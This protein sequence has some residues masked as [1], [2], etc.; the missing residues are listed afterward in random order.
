MRK[1]LLSVASGSLLLIGPPESLGLR[2]SQQ[3]T[4]MHMTERDVMA[5]LPTLVEAIQS[6]YTQTPDM[7]TVDSEESLPEKETVATEAKKALNDLYDLILSCGDVVAQNLKL[8][9]TRGKKNQEELEKEAELAK[10]PSLAGDGP[11]AQ[12]PLEAQAAEEEPVEKTL[13]GR[14][15]DRVKVVADPLNAFRFLWAPYST[16][17]KVVGTAVEGVGDVAS[18]SAKSAAGWFVEGAAMALGASAAVGF[19][20]STYIT[21]TM[22]GL[23]LQPLLSVLNVFDEELTGIL[24]QSNRD[25]VRKQIGLYIEDRFGELVQPLK[26]HQLSFIT[27]ILQTPLSS[28]PFCMHAGKLGRLRVT[29]TDLF[30]VQTGACRKVVVVRGDNGLGVSEFTWILASKVLPKIVR[31]MREMVEGNSQT[32]GKSLMTP[33]PMAEKGSRR[34]RQQMP[35]LRKL[36]RKLQAVVKEAVEDGYKQYY[37]IYTTDPA[38]VSRTSQHVSALKAAVT[39][40]MSDPS[41]CFRKAQEPITLTGFG[42]GGSLAHRIALETGLPAVVFNAIQLPDIKVAEEADLM[43]GSVVSQSSL[44]RQEK[45]SPSTVSEEEETGISGTQELP[46]NEARIWNIYDKFSVVPDANF[47]SSSPVGGSGE[48]S[49]SS[50]Y[51]HRCTFAVPHAVCSENP[52]VNSNSW[53]SMKN[54]ASYYTADVLQ[55]DEAV[56]LTYGQLKREQEKA[57]SRIEELEAALEAAQAKLQASGG[58]GGSD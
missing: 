46:P 55:C 12:T 14:T 56:E 58:T 1:T 32:D 47:E 40:S 38:Y 51:G 11:Q 16:T 30:D 9:I 31:M 41:S 4:Q 3:E 27:R 23:F 18:T 5:D 33:I 53:V 39:A 8:A 54:Y 43:G 26:S 20:A 36:L 6:S 42:V 29:S 17:K 15:F 22:A 52:F 13:V 24:S 2:L 35:R 7:L 49:S 45:E 57:K 28:M 34:R 48:S 19:E 25:L 44:G 37:K 21:K 50:S 10:P